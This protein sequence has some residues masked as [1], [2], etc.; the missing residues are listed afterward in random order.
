MGLERSA[1]SNSIGSFFYSLMLVTFTKE[2]TDIWR[3][4]FV[5]P[6]SN[7]A[8]SEDTQY[9]FADAVTFSPEGRLL[10]DHLSWQTGKGGFSLVKRCPPSVYILPPRCVCH[11]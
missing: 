4:L 8:E 11:L 7:E 1:F 9:V 10:T 2:M 3:C 5:L 6:T